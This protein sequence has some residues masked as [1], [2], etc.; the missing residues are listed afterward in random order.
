MRI[1]PDIYLVGGLDYQLTVTDWDS[2]DCNVYIVDTG[3][4]LVMVDCGCGETLPEVLEYM[5]ESHGLKP[6]DISHLLLTHA[7]FD[8]AAAAHA[9]KASK[10][11][12]VAHPDAAEVLAAG[13][14]R[15]GWY[16]FHKPFV[17]TQADR[18]VADGDVIEVGRC[19]FEVMALPGHAAGCVAYRMVQNRRSITFIGDVVLSGGRLGPRLSPDFDL[20]AYRESLARL[21]HER[22]DAALPGHGLVC[23]KRAHIWAENCYHTS[24]RAFDA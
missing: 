2:K 12:I 13:D 4:G 3:D 11:E 14:E 5:K 9:L 15:T 10:V 20:E 22:L 18:Q 6:T 19:E 1:F 16:V 17:P 21:L 8:H 7:H 24:Q 23:M